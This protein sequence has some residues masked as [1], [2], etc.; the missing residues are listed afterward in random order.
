[1]TSISQPSARPDY[2]RRNAELLAAYRRCPSTRRRNAVV[3]ANL[4]LVRRIARQEAQRS[5]HSFDD[6][7]QEGSCGLIQAVERFDAHW[8]SSLSSAAVPWIRGAMRHY[9]RDRCRPLRGSHHLLELHR[10]G[11]TLQQQRWHQGLPALTDQ[12]LAEA[13][14][15]SPDRWQQAL[16]LRRAQR[17]L[18]L[19]QPE[20]LLG[21]EGVDLADH[22]AD[23][24]AE[25]PYAEAMRR[26]QRHQLW[27]R[28]RR[29]QRNQR[30]LVL[31]RV[32]QQ[33][34]WRELGER[35]GTSARVAQRRCEQ[36]LHQLRHDLTP[37]LG[38][39]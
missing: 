5:G 8:G 24:R 33:C 7:V 37:V 13:L 36:L 18:S 23:P 29:L 6:L 38:Q 35:F 22:L 16:E 12:Q 25:G 9:L 21:E 14:G 11:Q 2:G 1:M 32:L 10:K 19:D 30:R 15:C 26:E 3:Q 34:S 39:S 20:T 28:L 4:A 27:Q 31:G 17:L